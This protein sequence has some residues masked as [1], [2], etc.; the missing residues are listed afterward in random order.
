MLTRIAPIFAVA[1]CRI[2]HSAQFGAQIP[3]RSPFSIPPAISPHATTST[4][5]SN[6]AYVHRRPVATSTSAS[7]SPYV[8]TVRSRLAPIVSP[9][10]GTSVTPDRYDGTAGA[11]IFASSARP[12]PS[13]K[14]S[15]VLGPVPHCPAWT[16]A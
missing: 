2:V 14:R 9:S 12:A 13:G 15:G 3:T 6:S 4:S 1:Y 11:L 8:A 10:N 5:R 7:R 16:T